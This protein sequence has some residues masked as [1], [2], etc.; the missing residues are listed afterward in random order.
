MEEHSEVLKSNG[1]YS[2]KMYVGGT[3]FRNGYI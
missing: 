3:D 1:R 2:T